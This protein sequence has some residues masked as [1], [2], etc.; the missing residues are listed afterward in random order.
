MNNVSEVVRAY[1]AG[2]LDGEGS[3]QLNPSKSKTN[4]KKY[5]CL[6]VQVSSGDTELLEWLKVT[7]GIGNVGVYKPKGSVNFRVNGC[8]RCYSKEAT[9]LLK[10]VLPY[11][12]IKKKHAETALEF[13]EKCSPRMEKNSGRAKQLT[14]ELIARRRELAIE[15][16]MLNAKSGKTVVKYPERYLEVN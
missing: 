15:L 2:I 7:W 12:R 13:K 3:V 14:P 16:A 4:G 6:T 9:I 11:L 10:A 5:W 8:W 1:T